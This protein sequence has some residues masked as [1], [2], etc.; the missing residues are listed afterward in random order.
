MNGTG[1]EV[2]GLLAEA[3]RLAPDDPS[4]AY[5]CAS[6]LVDAGY[7]KAANEVFAPR[8]DAI[9]K[10]YP[11]MAEQLAARIK[12]RADMERM[13]MELVKRIDELNATASRQAPRTG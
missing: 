4:V 5:W 2:V 11:G 8:R 3:K 7:G 12:R 6:T 10:A 1:N 13:P 9:A